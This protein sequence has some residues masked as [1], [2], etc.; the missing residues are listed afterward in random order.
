MIWRDVAVGLALGLLLAWGGTASGGEPLPHIDPVP[1]GVALV[2][3]EDA[4]Q[5]KPVAHFRGREVIVVRHR[6]V[7]QALVG[8]P[9]DIAP[10]RHHVDFDTDTGRELRAFAVRPKRYPAQYV[11]IKNRDK[12]DPTKA[13]LV[14]ILREQG[15]ISR[16]LQT[17]SDVPAQLT[18]DLPVRGRFSSRF[19]LR[20][21]FND[22]PRAPHTGLDIAAPEG[23]PVR[24]PADGVVI[25]IGRYFFTGN[26]VTLDH[27]QGL[28]SLYCHLSRVDV[29]DGERLRRGDKIGEVGM[30]GRATGPHLHWSV[31]LN[32]ARV[33]PM[34]F[35]ARPATTSR[36][37]GRQ[38]AR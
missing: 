19:G 29:R 23:T 4:A 35:L 37:T 9:L 20:R 15:V 17:W 14:R 3:L 32:D 30:T 18:F 6:G 10:G 25:D 11:T 33:D 2:L 36:P 16:N 28:V 8:L 26:T 5:A 27:G 7:W 13:E 34:L 1:G 24:A 22:E 21:F 38:A 12:V 31:S